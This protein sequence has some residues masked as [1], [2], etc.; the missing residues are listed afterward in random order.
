MAF[1]ET[2]EDIEY[3]SLQLNR[4]SR[5]EAGLLEDVSMLEK[6]IVEKYG[7]ISEVSAL[8]KELRI[9]VQLYLDSVGVQKEAVDLI[10]KFQEKFAL[11]TFSGKPSFR[12]QSLNSGS[13]TNSKI[14]PSDC[15][16]YLEGDWYFERFHGDLGM[17][18]SEVAGQIKALAE[19][20]LKESGYSIPKLLQPESLQ[21]AARNNPKLG[22]P[23]YNQNCSRCVV[24][25]ELRRRGYRATPTPKQFDGSQQLKH[26]ARM[27]IN[28]ETGK[29]AY[30]E[31]KVVSLTAADVANEKQN[32]ITKSLILEH[33]GSEGARGLVRLTHASGGHAFSWEIQKG[34]VIWVDSQKNIVGNDR[35]N[36]F[37]NSSNIVV[38]RLDD[39]EPTLGVIQYIEEGRK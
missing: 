32:E 23:G 12:N 33:F 26:Y 35:D 37:L 21:Q 10:Q 29:S 27:F 31:R 15:N 25:Y 2:L 16:K 14:R 4:I 20:L 1:R 19:T 6:K 18:D 30:E 13:E 22:R 3:L 39:K 34:K 9:L 5:E 17:P 11:S 7:H 28:T 24:A 38:T 8:I 36:I